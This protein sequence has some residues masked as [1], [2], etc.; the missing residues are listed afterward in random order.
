MVSA[1]L[2]ELSCHL[3]R[4]C[5]VSLEFIILV[6]HSTKETVQFC[7]IPSSSSSYTSVYCIASFSTLVL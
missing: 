2:F 5:Y 4:E 7:Y 1:E 3:K 6:L